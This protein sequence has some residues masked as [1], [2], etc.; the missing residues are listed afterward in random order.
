MIGLKTSS[1]IDNTYLHLSLQA[2]LLKLKEFKKE[3]SITLLVVTTHMLFAPSKNQAKS[4]WVQRAH[5][6]TGASPAVIPR[7]CVN[8][9][10]TSSREVRPT[11]LH[12]R[13]PYSSLTEFE[14]SIP[15]P[16]EVLPGFGDEQAEPP[17]EGTGVHGSLE[18]AE[19]E[20]QGLDVFHGRLRDAVLQA[21]QTTFIKDGGHSCTGEKLQLFFF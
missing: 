6:F 14:E 17:R 13:H 5:N 21:A 11:R 1:P 3:K 19:H 10:H 18:R 7:S 15:G 16:A 12:R 20:R 4:S 8:V 2:C 9:R